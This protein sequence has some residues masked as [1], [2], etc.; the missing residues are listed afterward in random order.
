MFAAQIACVR[1]FDYYLYFISS[2]TK[3]MQQMSLRNIQRILAEKENLS[4]ELDF[5]M[6][7]LQSWAKE[8]D[9]KEALTELEKQKLDED[10]K[11]VISIVRMINKKQ[12]VLS[13]YLSF[14]RYQC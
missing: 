12:S 4:N 14:P 13:M 6:R 2:E 5:K 11:K 1:V 8:L 10:K 3:K 7:K 9:K